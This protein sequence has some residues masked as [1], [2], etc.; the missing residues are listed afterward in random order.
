METEKVKK[1]GGVSVVGRRKEAVARVR[2][3]D[4]NGIMTVK[5]A[6]VPEVKAK[7]VISSSPSEKIH[8]LLMEKFNLKLRDDATLLI[9]F[10]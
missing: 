6:K 3:S 2:L 4:G 8:N 1:Y 5:F 9:G 10:D 7:N